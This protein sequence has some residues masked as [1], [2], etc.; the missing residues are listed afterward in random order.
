MKSKKTKNS[1]LSFP[2]SQER[3]IK[4]GLY[5]PRRR[6]RI[7]GIDKTNIYSR[8]EDQ[9]FKDATEQEIEECYRE[10]ARQIKIFKKRYIKVENQ[11]HVNQADEQD[12]SLSLYK[13][14]HKLIGKSWQ[15]SDPNDH[16]DLLINLCKVIAEGRLLPDSKS[17]NLIC[18]FVRELLP[19]HLIKDIFNLDTQ[20][21]ISYLESSI[22]NY[23]WYLFIYFHIEPCLLKIAK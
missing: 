16:K 14:T 9:D 20:G 15:P 23:F 10:L 5:F 2:W 6:I 19:M 17:F 21:N 12:A 22:K 8:I 11:L 18:K 1:K 3:A 7:R 4:E 13:S